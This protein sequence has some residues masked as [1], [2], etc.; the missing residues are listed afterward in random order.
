MMA[1]APRSPNTFGTKTRPH[2]TSFTTA[3]SPTSSVASPRAAAGRERVGGALPATRPSGAASDARA[4]A[5]RRRAAAPPLAR[6]DDGGA[7]AAS[8]RTMRPLSEMK[9]AQS[10]P[11]PGPPRAAPPSADRSPTRPTPT[12]RRR[13][14]DALSPPQRPK[15]VV[16]LP[17]VQRADA[18]V[19]AVRNQQLVAQSSHST[20]DGSW[21]RPPSLP[22]SPQ[23]PTTVVPPP[24]ACA[25]SSPSGASDAGLP[26]S[27]T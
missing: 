26:V 17:P 16:R 4:C 6:G 11:S 25:L 10:A 13:S 8:T 9:S 19:A 12:R 15:T 20:A 5:A 2:L 22:G 27:A 1:A 7:A 14:A 18:A 21:S 24:P 23:R 3:P